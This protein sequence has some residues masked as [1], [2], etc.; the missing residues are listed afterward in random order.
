MH[1]WHH[2]YIALAATD[3]LGLPYISFS[4]NFYNEYLDN[5]LSEKGV[6]FMKW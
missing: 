5:A 1:K 2:A 4:R 3:E 6:Y